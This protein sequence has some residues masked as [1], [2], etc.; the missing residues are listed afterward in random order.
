M[1]AYS[2]AVQAGISPVEF[3]ELTPYLTHKA[4]TALTDGRNT[5]AWTIAALTR[6]KKM[7]KLADM[8]S[9]PTGA[10]ENMENELKKALIGRKKN[11]H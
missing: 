2:A 4:I 3:W 8:T 1:Q 6:A 11:G 5:Q 7:P 9:K 10:R